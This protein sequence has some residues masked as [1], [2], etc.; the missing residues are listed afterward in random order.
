MH[1][2]PRLNRMARLH[3]Q[4]TQAWGILSEIIT[5]EFVFFVV[6]GEGIKTFPIQDII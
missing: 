1:D 4:C 3:R 5:G 2:L 6:D